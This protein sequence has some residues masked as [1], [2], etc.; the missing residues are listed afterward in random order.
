MKSYLLLGLMEMPNVIIV[1]LSFILPLLEHEI[2]PV[3]FGP[4]YLCKR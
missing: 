1:V 3:G 2:C 4:I